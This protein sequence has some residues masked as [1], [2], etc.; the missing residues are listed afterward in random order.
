MGCAII[1]IIAII[2]LLLETRVTWF[3]LFLFRLEKISI[4]KCVAMFKLAMF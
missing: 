4:H 2:V 1:D 3:I